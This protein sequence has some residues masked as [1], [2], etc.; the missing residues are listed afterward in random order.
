MAWST[1]IVAPPDGA[2]ADYMASLEKLRGRSE[3]IYWPGHGGPVTEPQRF[4]RGLIHHRRQRE[5]SILNQL[6]AGTGTISAIVPLIYQ[7]LA[8]ALHGAAALSVYAHLEDLV[9]RGVVT[10]DA[11]QPGLNT[12]YALA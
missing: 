12:I 4:L 10:C 2:M 5:I 3:A 8:P 11:A 9:T 1:T 6:G 7:G